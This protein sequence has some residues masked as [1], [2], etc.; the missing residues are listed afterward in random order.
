[1][2]NRSVESEIRDFYECESLSDER[3]VAIME[4]RDLAVSA[5]R[6]RRAAV[7]SCFTAAAMVLLVIGLL[8]KDQSNSGK[9]SVTEPPTGGP[10]N[11]DRITPGEITAPRDFISD[12]RPTYRLVAFRS[13]SDECPHCR[14]TGRV[15]RNLIAGLNHSN[16]KL[17]LLDLSAPNERTQINERVQ[18][19]KIASL[20]DGR[21]ETAFFALVDREGNAIQEF[22]PSQTADRIATLVME[23]VER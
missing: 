9:L 4:T 16:V 13:H 12:T 1:M 6:W 10:E 17:E 20:I 18:Q 3:V 23:L 8:F 15:Y 11:L 2:S 22:K 14:E 19:L 7:A 21:N 5:R